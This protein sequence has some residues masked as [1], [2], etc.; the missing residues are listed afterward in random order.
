LAENIV[1]MRRVFFLLFS[2]CAFC[3]KA[4]KVYNGR[5]MS[6]LTGKPITSAIISVEKSS[7]NIVYGVDSLGYFKIQT[8][9]P[10]NVSLSFSTSE[11]G[12][13]QIGGLVFKE[14]DTLVIRLT[15]DCEY[16]ASRD[17]SEGKIKL[18]MIFN[19]FSPPLTKK[20][21]AFEKKYN[22]TYYGY[23]DGCTGILTDCIDT[24]NKEITRYLDKKYGQKWR[25][26]ITLKVS[27]L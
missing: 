19:A 26:E 8:D 18:L 1:S 3:G 14:D 15:V 23:G 17:I 21:K 7:D 11:V 24:Y 10:S 12:N 5:L 4:Q 27:G 13:I 6:A 20:D 16:S 25:K 2:F 9:I 22:L